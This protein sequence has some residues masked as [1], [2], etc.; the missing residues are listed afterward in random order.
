M[1]LPALDELDPVAAGVAHEADPR[2]AGP[3]PV[4]RLLRVDALL[5]EPLE[6]PVEVV[7]GQGDVVV[8]RA[9]LVRVDA[10]VVGQLQPV[11]VPRDAHE[12]VDRL[13]ADGHAPALLEPQRL[14]E[15]DG[16]VDVADPVA[17]VDEFGV[18]HAPT[19]PAYAA[20]M[21][22]ERAMDPDYLSNT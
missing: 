12:D 8:A 17:R 15:G 5:G 10:E 18:G 7:D 1:P 16:A 11:A 3:Q 19:V 4:G 9:E 13:V 6:R 2:A 21:I 20:R 22:V 14:V